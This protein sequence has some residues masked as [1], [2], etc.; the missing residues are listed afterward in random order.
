MKQIIVFFMIMSSRVTFILLSYCSICLIHIDISNSFNLKLNQWLDCE[1]YK[2]GEI[3][4]PVTFIVWHYIVSLPTRSIKIYNVER[5]L[6]LHTFTRSISAFV[7]MAINIDE[8][9]SLL[10]ILSSA[11]ISDKNSYKTVQF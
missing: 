3:N 2:S 6:S 1:H 8:F 10:C 7:N 9:L 4:I 5:I 11:S